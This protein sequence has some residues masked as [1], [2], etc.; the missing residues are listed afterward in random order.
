MTEVSISVSTS[1]YRK[2]A[3]NISDIAQYTGT[4]VPNPKWLGDDYLCMTTGES[5]FPVRMIKKEYIVES[6]AH[7]PINKPKQNKNVFSVKGSKDQIYTVMREGAQ[8]SCTC[9][10]FGFRRDC[11]HVAAAKKLLNSKLTKS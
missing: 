1:Y 8:W 9:V 2:G 6:S 3:A 11:K 4:I 5:W 7:I 10:G